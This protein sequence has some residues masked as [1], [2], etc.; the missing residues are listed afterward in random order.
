MAGPFQLWS[1]LLKKVILIPSGVVI[2]LVDQSSFTLGI[3]ITFKL[4]V[5]IQM[6][7]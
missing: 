1:L 4:G 7:F 2:D 5:N 3:Y 6:L